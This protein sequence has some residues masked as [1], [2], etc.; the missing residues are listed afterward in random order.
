M[1]SVA[2]FK[3]P[4][5]AASGAGAIGRAAAPAPSIVLSGARDAVNPWQRK[6]HAGKRANPLLFLREGAW[7]N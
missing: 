2:A 1:T 7:R 3:P 6:E 5:P 4:T